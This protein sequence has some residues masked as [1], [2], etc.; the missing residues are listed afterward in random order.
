MD[1]I[2][3]KVGLDFSNC[4]VLLMEEML[5][6][7]GCTKPCKSWE[8]NYQLQLVSR[9]SEPSTVFQANPRCTG[10]L[11]TSKILPEVKGVVG[12]VCFFWGPVILNL[13]RG[14]WMFREG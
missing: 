9:I 3:D 11:S 5:H 12:T 14:Q 4:K 1:I 13:R 7:L 10:P 2:P 8:F 6:H